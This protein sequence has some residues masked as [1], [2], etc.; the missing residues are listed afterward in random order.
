MK[1]ILLPIFIILLTYGLLVGFLYLLI[2]LSDN[3]FSLQNTFNFLTDFLRVNRKESSVTLFAVG[4]IMLDRGVDKMVKENGGSNFR[5]PFF[6]VA[7]YL[8]KADILFGNLESVISDKEGEKFKKT[9][10]VQVYFKA[11]P[12][13]I[14]GLVYADFDIVSVANNHALDYGR[15]AFEDSLKRLKDAGIEYIGG[16]FNE[17]EVFSVKIQEIKGTKIGFLSYTYPRFDGQYIPWKATENKSGVAVIEI[18]EIEKIKKDIREAKK[19][20]DILIISLH[21]GKEYILEPEPEKISLARSFID[22][23]ADLIIGHHPHTLQPIEK[24][25]NGWI[26][27]SLGNFVFD[28]TGGET[29]KGGLLEVVIQ[30]KKIKEIKLKKIEISDYF[31][32]HLLEK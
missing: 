22:A 32:P 7:D 30:N 14:E 5:F 9:G 13:A 11:K 21:W 19:K 25:K 2:A 16:G 4:D 18:K 17:K 8:K 27:Y 12:E 3:N 10:S 26:A 28:M 20:V 29:R 1:K 6:F 23:G 24:Y 15:I 31:Q